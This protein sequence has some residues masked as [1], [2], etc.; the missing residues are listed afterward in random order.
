MNDTLPAEASSALSEG[1]GLLRRGEVRAAIE[2]LTRANRHLPTAELERALVRVRHQGCG[3][4]P[5]PA[6]NTWEPV[7]AKP[8]DGA[9]VEIDVAELDAA[10]V[11]HGL[12]RSGCLLV[13]GLVPSD[14]AERLVEGIDATY[15]AFDAA[16]AEAPY[17][18]RWFHPF[19]MPDVISPG[20][21]AG[22]VRLSPGAPPA[23]PVARRL[24]RK[25]TREGAGIW[26]VDSP[27][28]LFEV[29]EVVDEVRLGDVITSYL[30]E[31]PF[32]SANKCTLRRVPA[33]EPTGGWHQDGAFLGR[34]VVS[35][36]CWIALNPCGTDAPGIDVIPKRFDDILE[37]GVRDAFFKWSLS[38]ADV[39][40]AGDGASPVRPQFEAGD[41][42]LF[43]HR[44]V[45]RTGGSQAMTR[46]RY[47]LESW[48]FAPSAFPPSQRPLVY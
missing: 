26:T 20:P 34:D 31:R 43:D 14:A 29:L 45:H 32:L 16:M 19:P 25:L 36:N 13:R 12:E 21:A 1:D 17:D 24:H 7:V 15:E 9:V 33:K 11:R 4:L 41:A 38:D 39:L 28:M 22:A 37:P 40:D 27:R 8:S 48:W 30:G 10:A 3:S 35:L 18:P 5:A 44:L 42:L 2:V 46:E 6:P 23:G 47:A